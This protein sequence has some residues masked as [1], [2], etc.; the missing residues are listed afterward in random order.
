MRVGRRANE[1]NRGEI[2]SNE[3]PKYS[4]V[5]KR[6]LAPINRNLGMMTMTM[7]RGNGGYVFVSLPGDDPTLALAWYIIVQ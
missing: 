4:R 2:R 7:D 5:S 6:V 1:S 3:V